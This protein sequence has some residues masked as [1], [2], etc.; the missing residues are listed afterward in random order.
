[1]VSRK[2]K[3]DMHKIDIVA[4]VHKSG[5]SLAKLSIENGLASGTLKN[6]LSKKY[7]R[8]EQIIA[9]AVGM[10]PCEIWPLRY[11]GEV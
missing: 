11:E 3:S 1:M 9:D 4:L 8:G 6:A 2:E 10:K 7:P 5:T